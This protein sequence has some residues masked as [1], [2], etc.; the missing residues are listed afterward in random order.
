MNWFVKVYP[1]CSADCHVLNTI[2]GIYDGT[3]LGLDSKQGV[4]DATTRVLD[5]IKG[6]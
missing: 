2:K 6:V 1:N 4:Y 3:T 5:T